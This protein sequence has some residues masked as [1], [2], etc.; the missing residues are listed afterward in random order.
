MEEKETEISVLK[1]AFLTAYFLMKEY[2][3]NRKFLPLTEFYNKINVIGVAEIK[4]FQHRSEE[5]EILLTIGNVV[6]ELTLKKVRAA[7]CF[8]LIT[9]EMTD[10]SVVKFIVKSLVNF[11]IFYLIQNCLPK[12]MKW[13]I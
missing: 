12:C 11:F 13:H 4:Y 2:L 8:G 1:K 5:I 9:D 7:S 10:V 3:P 6:K